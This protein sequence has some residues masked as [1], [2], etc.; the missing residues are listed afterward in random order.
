MNKLREIMKKI[1]PMCIMFIVVE[2]EGTSELVL[3]I[4]E[5]VLL[6]VVEVPFLHLQIQISDFKMSNEV[7]SLKIVAFPDREAGVNICPQN[8]LT[9]YHNFQIIK[10]ELLTKA[11]GNA[12]CYLIMLMTKQGHAYFQNIR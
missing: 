6:F 10:W 5:A 4:I 11:V 7:N 1:L 3:D 2:D 8:E 9:Y 12:G